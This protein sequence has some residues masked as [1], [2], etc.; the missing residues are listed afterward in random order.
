MAA[1]EIVRLKQGAIFELGTKGNTNSKVDKDKRLYSASK[2]RDK[3]GVLFF[4]FAI[5]AGAAPAQLR[6]LIHARYSQNRLF[7]ADKRHVSQSNGLNV[8][9]SRFAASVSSPL[10]SKRKVYVHAK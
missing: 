3:W 2:V 5:V 4:W 10:S 8:I 9:A 7:M 6:T 1:I